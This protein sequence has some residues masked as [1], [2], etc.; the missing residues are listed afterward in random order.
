MAD[1]QELSIRL[2]QLEKVVEKEI[3]KRERANKYTHHMVEDVQKAYHDHLLELTDLKAALRQ[4]ILDDQKMAKVVE[5]IG[6]TLT[7]VQRLVWIAVGGT[8]IIAALVIVVLN[9][10]AALVIK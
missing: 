6:R 4:H 10:I 7:D 1:T 9:R 5:S 3:D 8:T 2:E